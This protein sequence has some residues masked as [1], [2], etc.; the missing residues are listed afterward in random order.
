[1]NFDEDVERSDRRLRECGHAVL[2][3]WVE[4]NFDDDSG[5]RLREGGR[6]QKNDRNQRSNHCRVDHRHQMNHRSR[7]IVVFW[8]DLES[9]NENNDPLDT[10]DNKKGQDRIVD[11]ELVVSHREDRHAY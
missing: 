6:I 7:R 4:M 5:R 9:K 10:P 11:H 1:M 8:S 2:N 3:G